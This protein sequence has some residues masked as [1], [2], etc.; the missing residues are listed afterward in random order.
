MTVP[1]ARAQNMVHRDKNHAS[2]VIWSL[3]NEAGGG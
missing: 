2:V 1:A 3:G